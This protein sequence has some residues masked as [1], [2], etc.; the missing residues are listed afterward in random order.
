MPFD[1]ITG[2]FYTIATILIVVLLF[3]LWLRS[4]GKLYI[5]EKEAIIE[6]FN[7]ALCYDDVFSADE[8]AIKLYEQYGAQD[9]DFYEDIN[10]ARANA[11]SRI[12]NAKE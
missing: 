12:E 3:T 1:Y 6:S 11:L 9:Q 10:T 8:D 2:W 4:N 7:Q 5:K